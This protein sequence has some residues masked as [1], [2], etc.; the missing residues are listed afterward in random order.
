MMFEVIHETGRGFSLACARI[1]KPGFNRRAGQ[2]LGAI[3][4]VHGHGACLS[5]KA[6]YC[7]IVN[8]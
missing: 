7:F 2:N 4:R 3:W 1:N 8:D 5:I 6:I